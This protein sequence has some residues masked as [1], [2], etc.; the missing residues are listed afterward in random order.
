MADRKRQKL[1]W[2][3]EIPGGCPKRTPFSSL[4]PAKP[5]IVYDTYW[6]FAAERQAIFFGVPLGTLL[7]GPT[8]RSCRRTSLPMSIARPIVLV[9]T[10]YGK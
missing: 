9:N 10:S 6:R 8:T 4:A 1:L 3:V 5:T 2:P 7:P